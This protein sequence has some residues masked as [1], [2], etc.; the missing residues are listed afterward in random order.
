GCDCR[1]EWESASG[2]AVQGGPVTTGLENCTQ[3]DAPFHFDPR[4]DTIERMPIE[5]YFG[6]A[7]VV[8]VTKIFSDPGS[9]ADRARQIRVADLEGA[10][11]AIEQT[12]RVLL[13]TGVW[14]D[15]KTF[16]D[17]IPVIAPDVAAWL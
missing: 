3:V 8:D 10:S 14:K 11:A 6:E 12:H 13:K 2:A 16:P 4:G 17:W 15:S 9:P 5:I 7:V 1:C